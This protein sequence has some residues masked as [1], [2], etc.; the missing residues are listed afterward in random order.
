MEILFQGSNTLKT[1]AISLCLFCF[2]IWEEVGIMHMNEEIN[3]S[4]FS[5]IDTIEENILR[6]LCTVNG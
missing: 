6:L 1:K 4:V 2:L 5:L 3:L